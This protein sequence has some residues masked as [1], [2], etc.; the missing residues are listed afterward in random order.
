MLSINVTE[1][2]TSTGTVQYAICDL[3]TKH[4]L[5]VVEST[6]IASFSALQLARLT[7]GLGNRGRSVRGNNV[8]ARHRCAFNKVYSVPRRT[9]GAPLHYYL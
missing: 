4:L 7:R 9:S 8:A 6:P 5:S 1:G 2:V 3:A